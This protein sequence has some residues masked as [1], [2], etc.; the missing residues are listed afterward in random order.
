MVDDQLVEDARQMAFTGRPEIGFTAKR[1]HLLQLTERAA[2]VV[3]GKNIYPLLS[4]FRVTVG[5]GHIRVAATDMELSV[6][7][8]STL[9]VCQGAGTV[10]IPARRFL[11]ILKEASEG[12]IDVRVVKGIA[13]VT[14]GQASWDLVLQPADDY[15]ALPS[16]SDI[17]FTNVNRVKLL[18]AIR[19][20]KGAASRDGTNP[21]LMAVCIRDG[22]VIASSHVRLHR[23]CIESFPVDLQVPIGAVDDLLRLLGDCQQEEIGIGEE[24]YVLAFRIGDDIF[25]VG[26]LASEYPDQEKRLLVPNLA[27]NQ[28]LTVDKADLIGAIRRVRITADPETAAI[29]LRLAP[30]KLTVVSRDKNH[31]AASEEIP[32]QWTSKERLVVVN[33]EHLQDLLGLSAGPQVIFRIGTDAGKRRSPLLLADEKI[34]TAGVIGQLPSVLVE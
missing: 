10:L 25:M 14:A 2:A 1:F 18:T 31:N 6:L 24:K 22:K 28:V 19:L 34:G 30:G 11:S 17:E 27:N 15:P 4:N 9:V 7:S 23:A 33:H 21:R 5:E 12:D 20:V 16:A 29:G 26:K 13:H 32:V 8:E 3:P